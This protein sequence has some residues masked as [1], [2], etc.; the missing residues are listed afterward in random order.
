M[1]RAASALPGS[2]QYMITRSFGAALPNAAAG[3]TETF[4]ISGLDPEAPPKTLKSV[5]LMYMPN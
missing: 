3:P 1:R 5:M 2:L 4:V